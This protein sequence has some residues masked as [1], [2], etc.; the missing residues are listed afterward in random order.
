ML[1]GIVSGH[2]AITGAVSRRLRWIIPALV[3]GVV[4]GV[5]YV[6]GGEPPGR[7]LADAWAVLAIGTLAADSLASAPMSATRRRLL[8]VSLAVATVLG[9]SMASGFSRYGWDWLYLS[10]ILT[11]LI[12]V[13]LSEPLEGALNDTLRSLADDG[14]LRMN[15]RELRILRRAVRRHSRRNQKIAGSVVGGA[16][17][18]S[19]FVFVSVTPGGLAHALTHNAVAPVFQSLGGA[20]AGQ[21]LGRMVAYGNVWRLL[22]RRSRILDLMPDHPDGAAGLRAI[23]RFHFRL[24][25]I[26]ALP[27][28]YLGAWYIFIPL[29]PGDYEGWRTIYL[30]LLALAIG[31]EVLAFLLPM[32][33]VHQRMQRQSE[34]WAAQA[35]RLVPRIRST[36]AALVEATSGHEDFNSRI[37]VLLDRHRALTEAPTWPIDPAL[38][39]WFTLNNTALFIPF[40]SYI[41]GSS[42][43]WTQI[44]TVIGGLKH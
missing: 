33:A 37:Q 29:V 40:L 32:G 38:R 24:S 10:G 31:F 7:V 42:E 44:A 5:E 34:R 14:T 6:L 1:L 9:V 15:N 26:V 35:S 36:Q 3:G 23:G 21:R 11:F 39:R 16:L 28:V 12:G 43:F 20:V 41:G 13:E 2:T 4:G 19:W 22:P 17:G 27:A 18:L 25:L 30:W 8:L